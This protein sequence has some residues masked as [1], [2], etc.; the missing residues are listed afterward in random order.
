MPSLRHARGDHLALGVVGCNCLIDVL[1]QRRPHQIDIP[2]A[3]G[4]LEVR[5]QVQHQ[6]DGR[7]IGDELLDA[8][9]VAMIDVLQPRKRRVRT[10][11]AVSGLL[12]R[13]Q[14]DS[15]GIAHDESDVPL[16]ACPRSASAHLLDTRK[17]SSVVSAANA[18][19]WPAIPG[20]L[21]APWVF[22]DFCRQG[23]ND[24][25]RLSDA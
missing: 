6:V 21:E 22:F 1:H 4:P 2:A 17:E 16:A 23:E 5:Q 13:T 24:F 20:G 3:L 18:P 15:V 12:R 7:R 19:C 25:F 8:A 9:T 14:S 11:A 10:G